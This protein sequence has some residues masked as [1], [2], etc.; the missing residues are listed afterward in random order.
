MI[1]TAEVRGRVAPG[2]FDAVLRNIG[3]MYF[4]GPVRGLLEV[5]RVLRPGGH[6]AVSVFTRADRALVGGLVRRAIAGRVPSKSAEAGRSFSPGD[7]PRLRASMEPSGFE[8]VEIATEA[9]RF[10]FASFDAYFGGVERGAGKTSGRTTRR[11]PRPRAGPSARR[12]AATSATRVGRSRSR[13]RSGSSAG[14]ASGRNLTEGTAQGR[15]E[16]PR[17]DARVPHGQSH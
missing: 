3:L 8:E 2:S 15:P 13:W 10:A 11:C 16:V 1:A 17:E 7:E 14:G 5:R 6:A 12:P 9:L 4:P